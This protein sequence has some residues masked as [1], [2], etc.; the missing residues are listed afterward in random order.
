MTKRFT[1]TSSS[2]SSQT[3]PPITAANLDRHAIAVTP[4]SASSQRIWVS[5]GGVS[6]RH[7][8]PNPDSWNQL[9]KRDSLAAD[10]EDSLRAASKAKKEKGN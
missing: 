9:V 5:D 3:S 7:A 8:A 2:S 4:S 1:P 10:I 6:R